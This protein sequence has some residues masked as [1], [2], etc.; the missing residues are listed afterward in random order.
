VARIKH[1]DG[2]QLQRFA[3]QAMYAAKESGKNR[4]HLFGARAST[5]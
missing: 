1:I 3:D 2:D 5:E 4:Y